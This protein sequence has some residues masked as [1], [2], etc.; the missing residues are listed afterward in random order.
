[1][2]AEFLQ[3][4]AVHR[5]GLDVWD[6][7]RSYLISTIDDPDSELR[8]A[9]ERELSAIG[10]TLA[11]DSVVAG[12]IN[13]W[14]KEVTVYFVETYSEE[15]SSVIS[16]TIAQWDADATSRRIELH[17][18]RDLQFIR[19]NGTLVGGLVGVVLYLSWSVASG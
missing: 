9:I 2:R 3:H 8:R 5:F 7:A 15:I 11:E 19:I 14:L 6:R 18:G 13:A 16:T 4:P 17:I 1:L 10:R 12:E